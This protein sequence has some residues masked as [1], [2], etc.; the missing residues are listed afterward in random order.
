LEASESY[1]EVRRKLAE[2]KNPED[3]IPLLRRQKVKQNLGRS[4]DPSEDAS[5][6]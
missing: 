4:V 6:P 5:K 1:S 3:T 2:Q